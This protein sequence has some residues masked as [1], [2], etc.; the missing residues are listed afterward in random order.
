MLPGRRNFVPGGLSVGRRQ[1]LPSNFPKRSDD[2]ADSGASKRAD[3]AFELVQ[4]SAW[5]TLMHLISIGVR[6]VLKAMPLADPSLAVAAAEQITDEHSAAKRQPGMP[7]SLIGQFAS[8][9]S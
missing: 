6:V 3:L 8:R 2:C 7:A 1:G 4:H 9:N 5:Q